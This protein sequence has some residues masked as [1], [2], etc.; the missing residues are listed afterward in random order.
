MRERAGVWNG[1][2]ETPKQGLEKERKKLK[3]Q[4]R[5]AT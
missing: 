3:G 4:R 5:A 1:E 2:R